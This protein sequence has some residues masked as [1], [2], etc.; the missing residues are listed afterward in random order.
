MK[1]ILVIFLT[2]LL[3]CAVHA[4]ST[5]QFFF[6]NDAI[7]VYHAMRES[8]NQPLAPEL[9]EGTDVLKFYLSNSIRKTTVYRTQTKK[10]ERY[11]KSKDEGIRQAT[12]IVS[13]GILL[14][15]AANGSLANYIE[16]VL[17]N[18]KLMLQQGTVARKMA[19]LAEITDTA[20]QSYAQ[21]AGAGVTFAL[22]DTPRNLKDAMKNPGKPVTKLLITTTE[23]DILK[24]RL[25]STFGTVLDDHS[26]AKWA[27]IPAMSLWSFL[28]DKWTPAIER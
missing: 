28:N 6:A 9:L 14:V 26:Q 10:L 24:S 15:E 8:S 11:S 12:A 4:Q 5:D 27:D 21:T 19:E 16:T 2:A 22:T 23:I 17:N 3:G 25:K 1:K 13:S 20:W 18:P 7:D